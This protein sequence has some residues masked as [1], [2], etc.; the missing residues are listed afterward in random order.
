MLGGP[1][2]FQS[3]SFAGTLSRV[4]HADVPRLSEVNRKV[5][6][7]L[8]RMVSKMLIRDPQARYASTAAVLADLRTIQRGGTPVIGPA[9]SRSR[10]RMIIQPALPTLVVWA[11]LI[12][13]RPLRPA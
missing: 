3:D 13:F 4:L 7:P 8:A 6:A 10:A 11:F 9:G 1:Q 12:P 5:P 2:P